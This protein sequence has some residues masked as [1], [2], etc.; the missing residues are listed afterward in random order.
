M[1][2]LQGQRQTRHT[3]ALPLCRDEERDR[4]CQP[5]R[6]RTSWFRLSHQP[7][8]GRS[9]ALLHACRK[10]R[11]R[12]LPS[13]NN[14]F[15]VPIRGSHHVRRRG[16]LRRGG[17]DAD[18]QHGRKLQLRLQ[19]PRHQPALQQHHVGRAQQL[20][21]RAHRLPATR[22]TPRLGSRHTG[23]LHGWPLQRPL[24]QLLQEMGAGHARLATRRRRLSPRGSLHLGR[25]RI[26]TGGMGRSRTHRAL[27]HLPHDGRQ[28][29]AAPTLHLHEEAHGLVR[30][31]SRR[32]LPLQ[33]RRHEVLRLAGLPT[34]ATSASATTPM[35]PS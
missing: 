8:L 35:L 21:Q 16:T 32:R 2:Q 18:H 9:N 7:A 30:H 17:R 4:R 19:P 10:G 28:G 15:R 29:C 22:R 3:P 25:P 11:R 31:A 24:A 1:G 14:L 5:R 33:R 23:L 26:R 20:H 34:N 27:Q 12:E 6:G 13:H